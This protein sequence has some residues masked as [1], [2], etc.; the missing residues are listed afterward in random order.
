MGD[1]EQ[2]AVNTKTRIIHRCEIRPELSDAHIKDY[3][4]HGDKYHPL[5]I[6]VFDELQWPAYSLGTSILAASGEKISLITQ[7]E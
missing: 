6:S 7:E 3:T 1:T 4:R 5:R 2:A